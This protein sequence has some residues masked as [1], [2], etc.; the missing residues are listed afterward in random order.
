MQNVINSRDIIF[1]A[2]RAAKTYDAAAMLQ[3]LV[4]DHL[5][6]RLDLLKIKPRVVL[7][8][9][10]GTGLYNKPLTKHYP[11]AHIVSMD[12]SAEM[13]KVNRINT[14]TWWRKQS[15][16]QSDAANLPFA[17]HSVDLIF[18]N[19]LLH[20]CADIDAVLGEIKRVLHP[21][22][23]LL[24]S[25]LGLGT[26]IELRHAWQQIDDYVHV[27]PFIDLQQLG[28][29]LQQHGLK[30]PVVDKEDLKIMYR[31]PILLFQD[32]KATG[33]HNIHPQRQRGLTS[34][35][36]FR[37]FIQQLQQFQLTD[38]RYSMN[39]EVIYGHAWG[40]FVKQVPVANSKHEVII[41][42]DEIK[43]RG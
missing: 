28:N 34:K 41:P 26:L 10:C 23:C 39:Y 13:L 24:F 43:P 15:Y 36:K 42:V 5:L 27:H 31:D 17:D 29:G 32:L 40:Q 6:E 18:S 4:G 3:R 37:N 22:G 2:N 25:T 16:C 38:G 20:W 30:N 19:L 9:G 33:S 1:S 14:R 12:I 8:L 11:R 21:E 7:D 35:S